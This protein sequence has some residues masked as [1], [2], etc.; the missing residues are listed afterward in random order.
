LIKDIKN[1]EK[2]YKDLL[3][4]IWTNVLN[5]FRSGSNMDS[6]NNIKTTINLSDSPIID[7]N[8]DRLR[9]SPFVNTLY[10]EITDLP[11]EDSFCFGL[12]GNWG[13]GK[14]SVL[15]LLKKKLQKDLDT[16]LFE[17][18]PWFLSAK[19]VILKNF[20]EGF[21]R[22]LVSNS[23]VSKGLF[24]KY[25]K[26]LSS[27][28]ISV[29][30]SG[31]QVGWESD[32]LC[33]SELK[34]EINSLIEKSQKKIVVFI[35]DVDRLQP[36]EILQ[37]FKLVKLVA[38][39]K[40]TIFI[41]SMDVEAVKRALESKKIDIEYI[42]KIVQKPLHLPKIE[43]KDIIELF[44]SGINDLL[45]TQSLEEKRVNEELDDLLLVYK[46]DAVR[47]FTTLRNVKRYI[48]SLSSSLPIVVGEVHLFD[49]I[50]LEIIKIFAPKD[51][52][53]DIYNNWWIYVKERYS[54]EKNYNPRLWQ[55]DEKEPGSIKAHVEK[56][57]HN[58]S[59]KEVFI[60]LLGVLFPYINDAFKLYNRFSE[61]KMARQEK[62]IYSTSFSKY[63]MLNVPS[64]ELSD[65][66]ISE[67]ISSWG[68]V[69]PGKI[70]E[71]I[72]E[73]FA[74]FEQQD[75]LTEFLTKLNLLEN[76]ITP[77]VAPA[78]IRSIYQNSSNFSKKSKGNWTD[79]KFHR[80][81]KLIVNLLRDKIETTEVQNVLEEVIVNT[82]SLDFASGVY[83]LC[84]LEQN[85]HP[86]EKWKI[87]PTILK[88]LVDRFGN[89]FV[90]PKVNFFQS[91]E[92]S[93]VLI[94]L[95]NLCAEEEIV[96]LKECTC[97]EYVRNILEN[98]LKCIGKLLSCFLQRWVSTKES[99]LE[100]DINE[101]EK[102]L[103]IN[104][105]YEIIVKEYKNVYTTDEEKE[106]VDL[107]IRNYERSKDEENE[108]QT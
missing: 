61:E 63:Y 8:Q 83:I 43:Q 30:G 53:N 35:D 58:Q 103:D 32:N 91:G 15:N 92:P 108:D 42:D 21:E 50:I 85:H 100:L 19:E 23:R 16:I 31:V 52:Y 18:D 90:K 40:H 47:L 65:A 54:Y 84:T 94:R 69:L 56:L 78:L 1:L 81:D 4:T 2:Q 41:L 104:A 26:R 5:I 55:N 34:E 102:Y 28:G 14:T 87:L 99:S 45:A 36:E 67:I 72:N 27:A 17:F 106:S 101:A 24:E 68:S 39:F 3:K 9:R 22:K 12:Y 51:L 48:S 46:R 59:K 29:L 6:S 70:T 93:Y 71:A 88:V 64:Q 79:S 82:D 57:L 86:N 7:E 89:D 37:V 96:D 107:F 76:N 105:F 62:R 33:P 80:A 44:T 95:W 13:E 97:A 25:F 73:N 75:E 38:D 10:G 66:L 60:N 11:L 49:F 20:L 98:E 77:E 74:S